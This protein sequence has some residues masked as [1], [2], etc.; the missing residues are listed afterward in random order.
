M[1]TSLIQDTIPS[2][3]MGVDYEATQGNMKPSTYISLFSL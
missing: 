3:H 1:K 2:R